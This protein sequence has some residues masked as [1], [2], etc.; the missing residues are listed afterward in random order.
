[1]K[2]AVK[3]SDIGSKLAKKG[4]M[5]GVK[6]LFIGAIAMIHAHGNN[7]N[8][9]ERYVP[10]FNGK[11]IGTTQAKPFDNIYNFGGF[12]DGDRAVCLSDHFGAKKIFLA[13]FDFKNVGKYSKSKELK[14]KKLGWAKRIIE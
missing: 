12:T 10:M 14:M 2:S 9:L 7:I 3:A 13:G 6:D 11:L 4:E 8:R 1:M 5:I